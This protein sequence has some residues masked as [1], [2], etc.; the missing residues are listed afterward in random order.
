MIARNKRSLCAGRGTYPPLT[1]PESPETRSCSRFLP[2]VFARLGLPPRNGRRGRHQ[3]WRDE[4]T[5]DNTREE[6]LPRVIHWSRRP[7][8]PLPTTT[9][10]G[11]DR[12][13]RLLAGR[14]RIG[15]AG[16]IVRKLGHH[17]VDRFPGLRAS[18]KNIGFRTE[19][20]GIG[21]GSAVQTTR[22]HRSHNGSRRIDNRRFL[23][24]SCDEFPGFRGLW[25]GSTDL[26]RKHE[27]LGFDR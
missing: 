7:S 10:G 11:G 24:W 25:A 27:L 5:N 23:V 22:R 17:G 3:S 6:S 4:R 15:L 20:C 18:D 16:W 19:P 8:P 26:T 13:R 12:R 14:Q 1:Q 21:N 2:Y 9:V